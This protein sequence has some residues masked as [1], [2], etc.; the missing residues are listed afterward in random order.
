MTILRKSILSGVLLLA[1]LI[2]GFIFLL[3]GCLAKYDERFI[4][5][6]A[7]LFEKDGKGVLFSIVEFQK[8][9]SYS[10]SG[11]FVRRSVSTS[12][13]IQ[14][15]D[16]ETAEELKQ[17]KV[18]KHRQIKSFPVEILGASDQQ[19]W[20]F[21][22]EPMA[23]D[24]WSLTRIADISILEEKNP[25]LKGRFPAEKQYY[26]FSGADKA[27][28]FTANNGTKWK[29]NTVTLQA[30]PSDYSKESNQ[31]DLQ[32]K[33]LDKE[34]KLL[35]A[36]Q[37]SLYQQ[38][39]YR[40]ARDYADKKISYDAYRKLTSEYYAERS[41]LDQLRDSLQ[42]RKYKLEASKR[43]ADDQEREIE[44]LQRT[45]ISFSQIK[46]NQD[47]LNGK[48]I[49]LYSEEELDKLSE[50]FS[51]QPAYDEAVR[52][53]LFTGS[54]SYN[55]NGDAVISKEESKPV[56][57]TDYLAGGFLVSKTNARPIVLPGGGFYLVVHKDQLGREGKLLVSKV[58]L[59]GKQAWV[60]NTGLT[61][62]SDWKLDSRRLYI[63]GVSNKELSSNETNLVH[64]ISL[65][66][67][68]AA[69]FDYFRNKLVN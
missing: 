30:T 60:F 18:K 54:F 28:Y 69:S 48:W 36:Y 26:H 31:S 33:V 40:A 32:L 6:P 61:E 23:F 42:K 43:D 37:D 34:I 64:C 67:G 68:R 57:P 47:T 4:H 56:S 25:S 46:Q 22:G 5:A 3:K 13:Y 59:A 20:I 8:T 9:T 10:R 55:R 17:V 12:Y 53:K 27:L 38:K 15:N 65:E 51:N 2:F 52:R 29:L 45:N 63:F 16:A 19:A 14:I 66:N 62:W 49:G 21:M 41:R 50:R 35:Q 1:L 7:L 11:G 44:Q 24:A 39:N 58:D